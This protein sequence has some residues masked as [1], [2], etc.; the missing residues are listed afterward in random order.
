MPHPAQP[1]PTLRLLRAGFR[2]LGPRLPG[3]FARLA[4]HLWFS[5][6]RF[7]EP[8]REQ[9]WVA[10]ARTDTVAWRGRHLARYQWGEP[11]APAIL[12]IHGWNGRGPQLGAF[13]GPLQAA[14]LRVVAFDAPAHGRSPG[15]HTTLFEFADALQT[16]ARASAPVAGAIA[17]SFGVPACARA[18]TQDLVLPRLVAI[19]APADTELLLA[20]F[21]RRLQIP[22]TVMSRMRALIEQ[23]FGVGIIARLAT[24][25]MLA[26]QALPG[27]IIHDRDDH[28]VPCDSAER[29]HRAWR[30]SQLLLT[31][32]LGHRRILR[33]HA[34]I[35][36]A[37]RFLLSRDYS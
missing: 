5:T 17:H 14:G 29:L 8:A 7:P 35:A 27:L 10:S 16:L 21:A 15:R 31:K 18:L 1:S 13:A 12:L 24:D 32:G 28:D 9:R 36:A 26:D 30:G 22:A 6:Q 34:V 33:D 2:H 37:V 25:R 11:G 23:R 19:A 20:G 4:C 3:P